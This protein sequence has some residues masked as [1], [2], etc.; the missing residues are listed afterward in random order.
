MIFPN[1]SDYI[2]FF[3]HH[4]YGDLITE[5]ISR[6]KADIPDD[7]A[8]ISEYRS[9]LAEIASSFEKE[10][11]LM[12][13][14]DDDKKI[15]NFAAETERFYVIKKRT[16][17]L[18][19]A[20]KAIINDFHEAVDIS[21]LEKDVPKSEGPAESAKIEDWIPFKTS[22]KISRAA[23]T[24]VKL[25]NDLLTEIESSPPYCAMQLLEG[26]RDIF[27]MVFAI[28]PYMHASKLE[29][30][31]QIAALFHNDCR[32]IANHLLILGHRFDSDR[33]EHLHRYVDLV[34]AFLSLGDLYLSKQMQ[35]QREQLSDSLA[36]ANGFADT[37]K[38]D[39]YAAVERS[40]N[41]I[42]H[43]VKFISNIWK[44]VLPTELYWSC[45]GSL[46]DDVLVKMIEGAEAL[47][48]I[49]ETETHKLYQLFVLMFK[50]EP[51]FPF[52]KLHKFVPHWNK[53]I[54]VTEIFELSLVAIEEHFQ[55]GDYKEFSKQE[56]LRFVK[57]L[58][59]DT[60][61]RKKFINKIS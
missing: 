57:A 35:K 48:D 56:L 49:S 26:P 37:H 53:F 60:P 18:A 7:T 11:K 45:M 43:Q 42:V 23:H 4:L 30:V 40:I 21:D 15:S 6:V 2:P 12:D 3:K 50:C 32:Y 1:L 34:P 22:L 59:A 29:N 27:D 61:N 44:E 55:N 47:D 17:A 58:F 10:L 39:R 41:Q 8:K 16:Q 14:A 5:A 20:R 31:P 38:E 36:S 9:K 28:V 19:K 52:D 54:R 33:R 25:S 13:I 46:I 24:L 51:L